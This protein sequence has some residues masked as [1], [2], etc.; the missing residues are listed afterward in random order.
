LKQHGDVPPLSG[1][2]I[3]RLLSIATLN[4]PTEE[5]RRLAKGGTSVTPSIPI[6]P[7]LRFFSRP[8]N[9]IV[10]YGMTGYPPSFTELENPPFM[11][12]YSASLPKQATGSSLWPGADNPTMRG[13]GLRMLWEKLLR[14]RGSP[15]SSPTAAG[16]T[17]GLGLVLKA[18][19]AG[20][21]S[22]VIAAWEQ[23][24]SRAIDR[25]GASISSRRFCR[26]KRYRLR[27]V[28]PGT[29]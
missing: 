21:S 14:R 19:T 4:L 27:A 22:S 10:F 6:Q 11:L 3:S 2:R 7:M 26:M 16:L 17:D 9:K 5:K 23:N 15:F 29:F 28:C 20:A 12:S 18:R 1:M 13:F 8:G 25:L 24:E